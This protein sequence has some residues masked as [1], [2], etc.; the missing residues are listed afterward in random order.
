MSISKKAAQVHRMTGSQTLE[1]RGE[2]SCWNSPIVTPDLS[3]LGRV[4]EFSEPLLPHGRGERGFSFA[5]TELLCKSNQTL[6]CIISETVL[7][8]WQMGPREVLWAHAVAPQAQAPDP[9]GTL[10]CKKRHIEAG[11]DPTQSTALT[12]LGWKA[13]AL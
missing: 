12:R 9:A 3:H 10:C 4:P 1:Q 6:L 11:P 5:P 8:E 7:S 13:W 2:K